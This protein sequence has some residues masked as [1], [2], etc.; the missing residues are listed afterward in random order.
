MIFG[1]IYSI[2]NPINGKKYIGQTTRKFKKR[3]WE[4][5]SA[6]TNNKFTNEHLGNAFKKYMWNNFEFKIIDTAQT[7]DELNQKEIFYIK[8]YNTTNRDFG[9]NIATGGNNTIPTKETLKKMSLAHLGIK[10]HDE[11]VKNRISKK[12]SEEA[13]KYG[14]SKTEEEKE[15]L[16]KISPKYWEGKKRS[17]ETKRKIKETKLKQKPVITSQYKEVFIWDKTNFQLLDIFVSTGIAAK[18]FNMIQSTVS[19]WC[20][21]NKIKDGKI[22]SYIGD[23]DLIKKTIS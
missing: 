1:Y 17:E 15:Y 3:I 10:Q 16:R 8:K 23:S 21:K 7:I 18:K 9:Y 22:W 12:G 11:W 19:R 6:Y 20:F 5:K 13:K 14:R 4:Y 2:N